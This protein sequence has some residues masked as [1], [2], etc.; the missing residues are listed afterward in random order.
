[1]GT[2]PICLWKSRHQGSWVRPPDGPRPQRPSF[3]ERPIGCDPTTVDHRLPGRSAEVAVATG[4]VVDGH[5]C[6]ASHPNSDVWQAASARVLF[7]GA[8]EI[9][10]YPG[11]DIGHHRH[12][13]TRGVR[14]PTIPDNRGPATPA[15]HSCTGHKRTGDITHPEAADPNRCAAGNVQSDRDH[16]TGGACCC[17]CGENSLWAAR[18]ERDR[19][20]GRAND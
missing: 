13:A 6:G 15:D 10:L 12:G 4:E 8:A 14:G 3:P 5:S 17:L 7:E 9:A 20:G 2:S 16:R 1:M 18:S 11:W 19:C